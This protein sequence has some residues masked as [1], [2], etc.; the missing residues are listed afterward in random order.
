MGKGT[1]CRCMDEDVELVPSM[2][3]EK[4]ELLKGAPLGMYHCP[5]CGAMVMAGLKHPDVCNLCDARN[6]PGIDHV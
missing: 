3:G 2:C 6:H 1:C 5:G 4:P